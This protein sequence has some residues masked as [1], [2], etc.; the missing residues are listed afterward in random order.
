MNKHSP[1][2]FSRIKY[3]QHLRKFLGLVSISNR[4]L[5]NV[6][7]T[8][9][10]LFFTSTENQFILF[11][12]FQETCQFALGEFIFEYLFCLFERHK[13]KGANNTLHPSYGRF[14]DKALHFYSYFE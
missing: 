7:G 2:I 10:P 14:C 9:S 8:A 13:S 12:I 4:I 11:Y 6:F 3:P 5:K 1:Y